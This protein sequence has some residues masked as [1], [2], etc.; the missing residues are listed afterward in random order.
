[1]SRFLYLL[2]VGLVAAERLV[3]LR[4]SRR[5]EERL[6]TR[7]ARE[8]GAGH[9]PFMVGLHGALLVAAP[10]EVWL[11]DREFHPL[12]GPAMLLVLA[13]TM[14]LRYWVVATLGVRWTTRVMVLP[15][16]PRIRRGPYRWARHP[17]YLA[18]GLEVVALPLVHSAWI[19]ALLFGLANGC[20]LA[21][22]IR[23]EERALGR[24]T[25]D[26]VRDGDSGTH[27]LPEPAR[28]IGDVST[29]DSGNHG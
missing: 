9:Y 15:G 10:L 22:R 23:V 24:G 1:M 6:R 13:A 8:T 18:V 26:A 2:L 20:L 25:G 5:N 21:V 12:V 29:P 4:V 3:E 28:K 27:P 11:L 19:T 14:A 16:A 17:N 7:G